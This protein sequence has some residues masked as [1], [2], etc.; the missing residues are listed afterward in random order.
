MSAPRIAQ[1]WLALCLV[2]SISAAPLGA[3]EEIVIKSK[4]KARPSAS[5]NKS[6]QMEDILKKVSPEYPVNDRRNYHQG[7][8]IYRVFVDFK[9][10][11]VTNVTIV[12]STGWQSLDAAAISALRQWRVKPGKWKHFDFPV[13]YEMSRSRE[14]AMEKIRRLQAGEER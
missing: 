1:G 3:Q 14:E 10:G 2:F 11:W 9:T 7:R 6:P 13:T 12:K 5:N 8:G 4:T